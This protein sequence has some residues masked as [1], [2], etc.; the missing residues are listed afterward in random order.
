MDAT[1]TRRVALLDEALTLLESVH[2]HELRKAS[3]YNPERDQ[4]LRTIIG[5]IAQQR[6]RLI[7][8]PTSSGSGVR[9]LPQ[10]PSALRKI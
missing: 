8:A 1:T 2:G 5:A 3:G 9:L 4:Q 10:R 7:A 6:R